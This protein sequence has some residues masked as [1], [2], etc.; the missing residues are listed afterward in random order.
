MHQSRDTPA[1]CGEDHGEVGCP[2]APLEVHD[3]ADIHLLPVEDSMP[4]QVAVPKEGHWSMGRSPL[5][6]SLALE[7]LK[8]TGVTH[9]RAAQ[10]MLWPMGVTH[11]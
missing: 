5:C 9:A 1:A 10:E 4:E 2:P 8:H 6:C 11:V 3:G 7:G